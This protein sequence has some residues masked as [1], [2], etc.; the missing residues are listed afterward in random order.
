MRQRHDRL[1]LVAVRPKRPLGDALRVVGEEHAAGPDLDVA[2]GL[3][4]RAERQRDDQQP[5][6]QGRHGGRRGPPHAAIDEV[7]QRQDRERLDRRAGGHQRPGPAVA[8][9][10]QAVEGGQEQRQERQVRLAE[11]VRVVDQ[12]DDAERGNHVEQR[13]ASRRLAAGRQ[14]DREDDRSEPGDRVGQ[15]QQ[16]D[17]AVLAHEADVAQQ[18]RGR[19][20]VHER[21]EPAGGR[22]GVD[23]V[24]LPQ[25]HRPPG[26]RGCN[27][28]SAVPVATLT[29]GGA[30]KT[31]IKTPS[32]PS[33]QG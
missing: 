23:V 20:R 1:V 7:A 33:S 29:S 8:S 2:D 14:P 16:Q 17:R 22:V 3:R 6:G 9:L 28:C 4:R 11:H 19:R 18:R 15:G 24:P 27:P 12:R 31:I 26:T 25:R 30:E 5:G 21:K 32:R 13:V 10:P